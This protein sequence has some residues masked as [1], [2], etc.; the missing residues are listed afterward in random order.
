[1]IVGKRLPSVR[2]SMH[3]GA[4]KDEI[5]TGEQKLIHRLLCHIEYLEPTLPADEAPTELLQSAYDAGL[6]ISTVEKPIPLVIQKDG[7][8]LFIVHPNGDIYV[9]GILVRDDAEIVRGLKAALP[10]ETR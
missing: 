1:M 3:R 4:F 5:G 7:I 10:N 8:D 2:L 6:E 9:R